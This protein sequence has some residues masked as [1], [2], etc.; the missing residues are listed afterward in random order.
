MGPAGA[1]NSAYVTAESTPIKNSPEADPPQVELSDESSVTVDVVQRPPMN[2]PRPSS[3]TRWTA[4]IAGIVG[5]V[6]FVATPFLPVVNTQSQVSW[7]QQNSLNSINVPL[8][9]QAP[10][11]LDIALPLSLVDE[12]PEGAS[13]LLST[14]H[15]GSEEP[16]K[17]GLLV[18]A[19]DDGLDVIVRNNA[20]L[21]LSEEELADNS[22]GVLQVSSNFVATTVEVVGTSDEG[23]EYLSATTEADV[24]PQITGIYTDLPADGDAAA[25]VAAGLDVNVVID[26]RFTSEPTTIKY[27]VMFLGLLMALA[28]LVALRIIDRVDGSKPAPLLPGTALRPR[29]LDGIVVATLVLWHIIGA[30]TSDDGYI[31]AMARVSEDSGYMANYFRWF[32]APES[33]FGWPYY[34]ILSVMASISTASMWMRL[35][36]LLSGLVVWFVISRMIIPR[37]GSEIAQRRVA[38]WS[39]AG[40]LL[41]FWLPY[42]NG[43]RPEPIVALGS[44]LTWVF[45]ERSIYTRRLFPAAIGVVMATLSLGSGPTGLMAL[46]AL[47]AGLPMLIQ[48][49]IDRHKALGGGVR[50]PLMQIAPFLAAGTAILVGVFG[51]QTLASVRESVRVRGVLGP[52]EPWFN[53]Y[54][55]YY[56][57]LLQSVDGSFTRRFPVLIALVC[58]AITVAALLRH[59][60]VPGALAGPAMRLVFMFVGTMF[61]LTFT[62]TK[63]THH[64]GVYAGIAAAMGALAAMALSH[65]GAGNR[66]NQLLFAG[67][68]IFIL[69]F[70]LMGTNGWWYVSS[71]GVPWFDKTVQIR[72]IEAGSVVL[73]IA[74]G[75]LAAGA[76]MGFVQQFGSREVRQRA[77]RTSRYTTVALGSPIAVVTLLVTAFS[78]ASLAKGAISQYP[79]YSLAQGNLRALTGQTCNLAASVLVEPD[80]NSGFLEPVGTTSLRDSLEVDEDLRGFSPDG[81]SEDLTADAVELEQSQSSTA[82]EDSAEVGATTTGGEAG[83]TDGGTRSTDG[84]NGSNVKLPFGL[85]PQQVPVIG[86]YAKGVQRGAAV[87]TAWY[88]LP[89]LRPEQPLL[90]VSAAG[91]IAHHDINGVFQYGQ[92]LVAQ[93]GRPGGDEDGFEV[94]AELEPIDVGPAPS[95]R[96]LRYLTSDFPEEATA[97][98]LVAEDADLAQDQWLAFTPPRMAELQSLND[99]LSEDTPILLD[100]PVSFQFPCQRPFNHYAGVAEI[101]EYRISPERGLKVV[102][103]DPWQAPDAGGPLGFTNAISEGVTIPGYLQDDWRRE[104]GNLE[105]LELRTNRDDIAPDVAEVTYTEN[106]QMGWFKPGPMI[107]KSP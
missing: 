16:T 38:Y 54:V 50:A 72:G 67:G 23:E 40:L 97:V 1:V 102:G 57:L 13:T 89:E 81:V 15:P 8:M 46:A 9:A 82:N 3:L 107:V 24:R 78:V 34:D 18:R 22:E 99:Y 49:V 59:R 66:R 17:R 39:A 88:E 95:W 5:F 31:F 42:N 69:A 47:L 21:S 43:L 33:P 62:P 75:T 52:S 64:F 27:L 106:T 61:F 84:V 104:W 96:N 53:E 91:R 58:L 80:V 37:L 28:S 68:F 10:L 70:S 30:S 74:L 87:N 19:T 36:A 14:V 105:R 103:V 11:E 83:S 101:P 94:L 35:P 79:A 12:L 92:R 55:R 86:S 85:N 29:V 100:W 98:R 25:A 65:W 56:W 44:L 7:P 4:I 90:V 20:L 60:T 45:I 73:V 71:Y 41:A 48:I 76:A 63:W 77:S 2:G 26:S 93:L 51:D 6:C 32:G